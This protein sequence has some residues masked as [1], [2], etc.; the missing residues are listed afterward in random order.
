MHYYHAK[1]AV[2]KA[3]R[4]RKDVPAEYQKIGIFADISAMTL[5]KRKTF[6]NITAALRDN[7]IAYGWGYPTKLL[8]QRNGTLTAII[9]PEEGLQ[10]L[11]TGASLRSQKRRDPHRMSGKPLHGR[12]RA[13]S[14]GQGARTDFLQ[15]P[16]VYLDTVL[17]PAVIYSRVTYNV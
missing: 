14:P 7:N 12:R 3:S 8:I 11:G 5:R 13:N 2:L 4:T 16:Q 10:K 15:C 1:E 6:G 17:Y 9:S